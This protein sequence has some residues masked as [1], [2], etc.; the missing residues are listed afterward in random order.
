MWQRIQTIYL[1]FVIVALLAMLFTPVWSKEAGGELYMMTV[2]SATII[3]DGGTII[4]EYFPFLF[5]GILVILSIIIAFYEI[6]LYKKRIAQ[7]KL[8]ALNSLI[9]TIA[10][11]LQV[12]LLTNAENVWNPEVQG[13]YRIGLFMPAVAIIFNMLANRNIRKDERLVRSVDRIR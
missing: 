1:F 10:L 3:Q 12:Y 13:T 2:F 7:M 11:G 8:G 4:T 9:M 5:V 6:T